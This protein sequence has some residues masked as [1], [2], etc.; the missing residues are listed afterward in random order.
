MIYR[1]EAKDTLMR[2]ETVEL[3]FTGDDDH[4]A[5]I[6]TLLA[7]ANAN[8]LVM[9]PMTDEEAGRHLRRVIEG[10]QCVWAIWP[11][12]GHCTGLGIKLMVDRF[13]IN[14]GKPGTMVSINAIA[15]PDANSA[16]VIIALVEREEL[17]NRGR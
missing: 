12:P 1:T 13:G 11:D 14:T 9:E 2:Y 10:H 4:D 8:S 15:C 7:L 3:P 16:D 17:G 6:D 5:F